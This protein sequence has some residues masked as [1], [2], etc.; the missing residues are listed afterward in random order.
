METVAGK[1]QQYSH[2]PREGSIRIIFVFV[3]GGGW[4]GGVSDADYMYV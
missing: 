4:G 1:A 3:C 2:L